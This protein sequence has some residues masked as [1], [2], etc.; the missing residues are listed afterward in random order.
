MNKVAM[1]NNPIFKCVFCNKQYLS[2]GSL[3]KHN[4][5]CNEEVCR[6]IDFDDIPQEA[7][8][9]DQSKMI[10]ELIKQNKELQLFLIEQNNKIMDLAK[11][12]TTII[13]QNN[14]TNNN[15]FNLNFFLN[16]QCKN[17]LNIQDFLDNMQLNVSDIEATGRLGYVNGIS[18]ILINKLKELDVYARPLHCTDYKRETI[19]IKD[20][21]IW[22]K[23]PQEKPKLRQIV[24][25]VA[26]KNLRQLTAWQEENPEFKEVA[27]QK[28]DEFVRISLNSLGSCNKEDEEKDTNKIVRNVLKEVIVE[29]NLLT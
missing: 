13:N 10:Y 12:Q 15:Q 2:R 21:D 27:T 17:A 19:Y 11:N 26:N 8:K 14:T 5:T 23:E 9:E 18:R 7:A 22:E 6:H 3:W 16:E 1:G 20:K 25:I 24:K 28:N 4:K 29:K